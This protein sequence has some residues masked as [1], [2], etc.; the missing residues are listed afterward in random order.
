MLHISLPKR[1]AQAFVHSLRAGF[2]HCGLWPPWPDGAKVM[3]RWLES[4]GTGTSS[5]TLSGSVSLLYRLLPSHVLW[6]ISPGRLLGV[7]VEAEFSLPWRGWRSLKA[8]G[9]GGGLGRANEVSRRTGDIGAGVEGGGCPPTGGD[10]EYF[11]EEVAFPPPGLGVKV[12]FPMPWAV[13]CWWTRG[14]E[15]GLQNSGWPEYTG[16]SAPAECVVCAV[17]LVSCMCSITPTF[18]FK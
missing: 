3:H 8:K 14:A 12:E 13:G 1:T 6:P 2:K 7:R 5:G 16:K 9:G 10:K 4:N 18:L 15:Q 17:N 11:M